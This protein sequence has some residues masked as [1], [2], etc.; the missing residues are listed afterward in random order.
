MPPGGPGGQGFNVPPEIENCLRSTVGEEVLNNVKTGQAPPPRDFGDKMRSC[1]EKSKMPPGGMMPSQEQIQ[2][3]IPEGMMR[4]GL[5]PEEMQRQIQRMVPQGIMPREG[6]TP[7]MPKEGMPSPEQIQ[8]MMPEG[9]PPE[10]MNFQ[11]PPSPEQIQNIQQQMME[12][13]QQQ[14]IQEMQQI[15]PPIEMAPP[16]SEPLPPPPTSEPAPQSL[17]QPPT[18]KGLLMGLLANF[19]SR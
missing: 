15:M 7:I 16:P 8:Q 3:I 9:V 4:E 14:M 13:V 19:L 11:Q 17:F 1:F 18:M 5:S 12:Q 2:G 10:M 6:S